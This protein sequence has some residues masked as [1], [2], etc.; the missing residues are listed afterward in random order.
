[1]NT[2]PADGLFSTVAAAPPALSPDDACAVASARY[3]FTTTSATPLVSERDQNF[4]LQLADGRTVVLKIANEQEPPLVTE[5]QVAALR[6]ISGDGT[7]EKL[8][9]EVVATLDG[10]D[11]FALERGG[12]RYLCRAVTYLPGV[13]MQGAALSTSLC[14][15]FGGF[16]ARLDGALRGFRHAGED[17]PLLWDMKRALRLRELLEFVE[18]REVRGLLGDTLDRFERHALSNFTELRWQVIHN[19]ANP[20]NVL[21]D[22]HARTV[23]GVIDYGDMQYSPLVVELAVAAAYLRVL[24]GDPLA[25]IRAFVAGY[26]ARTPLAAGELSLLHDLIQTRLATTIVI[27]AWRTALRGGD[28]AYLLQTRASEASALTFLRALS[29]TPRQQAVEA[30]AEAAPPH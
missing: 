3:G 14:Q 18:D 12:R 17:Q 23:V 11:L 26:H 10:D 13:P 8:A 5:F 28:D 22:E 16:L 21:T 2:G 7:R 1:M 30:F 20:G 27:M 29:N 9:P 6:H 19:D 25:L 24:D 15:D 4:C